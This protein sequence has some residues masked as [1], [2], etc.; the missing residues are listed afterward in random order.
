MHA[1][2]DQPGMPKWTYQNAMKKKT[3][4]FELTSYCQNG[5]YVPKTSVTQPSS[6]LCQYQFGNKVAREDQAD[7][8]YIAWK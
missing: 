3:M 4:D 8:H 7:R 1:D 5:N 6:E 2:V